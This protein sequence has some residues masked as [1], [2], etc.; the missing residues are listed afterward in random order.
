MTQTLPESRLYFFFDPVQNVQVT[1]LEGQKFVHDLVLTHGV[2]GG[3]FPFFRDAILGFEHLI[4]FYKENEHLGLYIAS[5]EPKFEFKLET[6]T[7]GYTR[8]LLATNESQAIQKTFDATIRLVLVTAQGRDPY[9]SVIAVKQV[10][11]EQALNHLIDQSLQVQSQ[12]TIS[13]DVDQSIMM[14]KIP[15]SGGKKLGLAPVADESLSLNEVVLKFKKTWRELFHLNLTGETEIIS[16]FSNLGLSY[17]RSIEVKFYCPC[18]KEQFLPHI[19][20]L[21]DRGEDLFERDQ[22]MIVCDYCKKPYEILPSDLNVQRI[23]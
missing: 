3:S 15:T 23:R 2:H 16:F 5:H 8:S 18:S 13:K 21:V 9:Q 11:V 4:Q 10:T 7:R 14:S 20:S 22:L 12:I 19:R 6:N 17:L 1:F